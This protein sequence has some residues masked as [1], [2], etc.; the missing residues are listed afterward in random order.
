MKK[1][2]LLFALSASLNAVAQP[3]T[4]DATYSSGTGTRHP[5]NFSWGAIDD[6][7]LQSDGKIIV[8]G[9]FVY[10]GG[11]PANR[12][13]RI[14][15]DGSYDGTFNTGTGFTRI[16]GETYAGYVNDMALQSDEKVLVT[17]IFDKYNDVPVK[18]IVRLNTDGTLDTSFNPISID[19]GG[20][21]LS[22]LVQPDGK[23][24]L[25]G[26]FSSYTRGSSTVET[27]VGNIIR[28]NP[29]GSVDNTFSTGVGF[30]STVRCM[31]IQPDGKILVGGYF[32]NYNG[33]WYP[34]LIRL[35]SDGS[36]D[37]GFVIWNGFDANVGQVEVA[38]D[39][40]IFAS[41]NFTTFDLNPCKKIIKLRPDGYKDFSF[42]VPNQFAFTNGSNKFLLQPNGQ[43]LVF[44]D[45]PSPYGWPFNYGLF[46]PDGSYDS[47][48]VN[49]FSDFVRGGLVQPDNKIICYGPFKTFNGTTTNQILRLHGFNTL[50]TQDFEEKNTIVYPNPATSQLHLPSDLKIESVEIT[51]MFGKTMLRQIGSDKTIAV[52]ALASGMYVLNITSGDK[53]H[54]TKF[55]K[56]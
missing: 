56:Q 9:T 40:S 7:V 41:G 48:F 4:L 29:D 21:F 23:I 2:A 45:G 27:P 3:G 18:K 15:A 12:I 10:Y 42:N 35:N 43:I 53:K 8:S 19:N 6:G 55:I 25:V 34:K 28:L 47:S 52:D 37:T 22:I 17:G 1:L 20:Y 24:I 51:D 54:Q 32:N 38:P 30:D 16:I 39:G 26:Y 49:N 14:N 13:A 36:A 5:V 11:H 33:H 50:D 46:N 44:A 31:A